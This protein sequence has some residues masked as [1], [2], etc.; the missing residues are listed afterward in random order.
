[1]LYHS[2]VG[3]PVADFVMS[4]PEPLLVDYHNITPASFFVRWEPVVAGALSLGRRQL[5]RLAARTTLGL[6]DSSFN[7]RELTEL[8]YASTAVVPILLDIDRLDAATPDPRRLELLE[9]RRAQG[10]VDWLFV[11]RIAPNKAQHDVIKALA[12]YRRFHDPHARLHLVG[13]SSS[14]SY[15]EAL[16]AFVD[17]LELGGAVD[18]AGPVSDGELA[19]YFTAADVF[20]SCSEHEGF[21]V[22]LLESMHRGLPIVAYGAAAVPE[23]LGDAGIVLRTKHPFSVA[24]AVDRVITDDGVRSRLVAAGRARL[25]E[26][27]IGRSRQKL[28][29]ALVPVIGAA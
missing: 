2:S 3:S 15:L 6:A 9:R 12:A 14:H 10:G 21:L 19:A 13:G 17:A 23:T 7:A 24:A 26:F 5:G 18:I 1:L 22:P 20:V 8:G 27:S 25:E 29:D 28:L 16:R 4:R 11:G